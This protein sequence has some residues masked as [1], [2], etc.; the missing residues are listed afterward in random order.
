VPARHFMAPFF[1]S[2]PQGKGL[3]V[4]SAGG[5]FVYPLPGKTA[6]VG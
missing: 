3:P 5:L 1:S 2:L 6:G 4:I